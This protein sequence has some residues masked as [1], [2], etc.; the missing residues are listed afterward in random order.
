MLEH[1]YE[2]GQSAAK[3]RK[4]FSSKVQRLSVMRSSIKCEMK[5][6]EDIV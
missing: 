6:I 4:I 2:K 5:D 1:P 3:R